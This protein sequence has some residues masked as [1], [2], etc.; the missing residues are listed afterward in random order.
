MCN[1]HPHTLNNS[2]NISKIIQISE[3]GELVILCLHNLFSSKRKK[4]NSFAP[5]IK[6]Y[7]KIIN[8]RVSK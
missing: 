5:Y 4:I 8:T 2:N 6:F 3:G 1:P 7:Y